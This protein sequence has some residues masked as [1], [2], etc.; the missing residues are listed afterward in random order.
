MLQPSSHLIFYLYAAPVDM[1]KSFD[2]LSGLVTNHLRHD[3]LAYGR[4]YLFVNRQRDKLKLL[5][6]DA[7]GFVQYYKRLDR[8]TFSYAPPARFDGPGARLSWAEVAVLLQGLSLSRAVM[9]RGGK[10][11][12][13]S[14]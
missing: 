12:K 7:G 2:G 4:V 10:S 9:H 8:G 14:G 13:K 11:S 6:Y 1:R 5:Y 3:A